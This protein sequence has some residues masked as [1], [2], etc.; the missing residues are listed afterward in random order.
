[1]RA[2]QWCKLMQ[3]SEQTKKVFTMKRMHMTASG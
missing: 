3:L 2:G 1:M